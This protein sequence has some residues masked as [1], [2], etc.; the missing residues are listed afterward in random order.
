[1]VSFIGDDEVFR[2]R[3]DLEMMRRPHLW[4]SK[5]LFLKNYSLAAKQ[6]LHWPLSGTL[7]WNKEGGFHFLL[8]EEKEGRHGDETL[9]AEL[10]KEGWLVD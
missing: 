10:V 2:K 7:S 3:D 8:E 4:P 1:M 9:L 5:I 6:G